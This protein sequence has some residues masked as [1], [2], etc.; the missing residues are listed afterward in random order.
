MGYLDFNPFGNMYTKM[1]IKW[2]LGRNSFEIRR[3]RIFSSKF[4][5]NYWCLTAIPCSRKHLMFDV[6]LRLLCLPVGISAVNVKC[7]LNANKK[8]NEMLSYEGNRDCKIS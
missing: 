3:Q 1:K 2:N 8:V 7:I 6:G 4:N 5:D